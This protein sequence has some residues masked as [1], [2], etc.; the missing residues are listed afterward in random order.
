MDISRF[1]IDRPRF[2]AV[3]SILV[4][5][6]G[7]IAL[8]KLPISEYPEVSPPQ[9]VVRAQFPGANP[10]VIAAT[11]ATPLEEQING[12]D[13]LL[14]YD[15]QATSDG[16]MTLDRH[17]PHR[18]RPGRGRIGDAEPDQSRAAA[19]ARRRAP[20]RRHDRKELADPD[21]GGAH[22]LA[23]QP[24]RRAVSAQLRAVVRARCA[25]AHPRHG[26]GAGVRRGRL[27]DAHLARPEQAGRA[28][29]DHRRSG[30]APSASR[31][32]RSPPGW[33][34]ARPASPAPSSDVGQH[35]GPPD[36]R[37]RVRRHHR[38][39]RPGRRL[40]DPHRATWRRVELQ[41]RQLRAAHAC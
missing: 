22:G 12:V 18:H 26:L 17:L 37:G 39:G 36:D 32:R 21:H 28:R 2:A 38:A 31:T 29:R 10:R 4:F 34:A 41:L 20:D 30:V 13:N 40:A 35:Q 1:F 27:R 33:S 5:L 19:P 25:V 9:V 3:L 23:R 14:Y 6:I 8:F 24:L 16:S 11:V 7:L 15:S